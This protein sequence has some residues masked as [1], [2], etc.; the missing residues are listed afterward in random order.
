ML[1]VEE[2]KNFKG[3]GS[4]GKPG[5]YFHSQGM[6]KSREGIRPGWAITSFVD[7]DTLSTL[8]LINWFTEGKPAS[9]KSD[10]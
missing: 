1:K 10:L 4:G 3:F 9:L 5:E 7:E 8:G 6:A 2:I